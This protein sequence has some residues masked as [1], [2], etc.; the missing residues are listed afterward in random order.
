[1]VIAEFQQL[2]PCVFPNEVFVAEPEA[3]LSLLELPDGYPDD[4]PVIVRCIVRCK[5]L[6]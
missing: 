2:N 5:Y 4:A 6:I 1:M 3:T